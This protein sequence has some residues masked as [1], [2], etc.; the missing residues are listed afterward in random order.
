MKPSGGF[1]LAEYWSNDDE[2]P[3]VEITIALKDGTSIEPSTPKEDLADGT[4]GAAG[5]EYT[6]NIR[7]A[8]LSDD[9]H[10]G[11]VTAE[12]AQTPLNFRLA[13]LGTEQVIEDCNDA[14]NEQVV[15]DVTSGIDETDYKVVG[16]V[17]LTVAE[18]FATGILASEAIS[19]ALD[20]T[21]YKSVLLFVKSSIDM[22]AGDLQLLLDNSQNCGSPL[23]TLNL[24]AL[25][26]GLWTRVALTLAT[27]ANLTGIISV[28]IKL[29][30]NK[31][32]FILW[33]DD[34]RAPVT[35]WILKRA[36]PTH[37]DDPKVIGAF[38]AKKIAAKA[39]GTK[40]SDIL[41]FVP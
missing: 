38:F 31:G 28:G 8:E 7:T 4:D 1:S 40:E 2:S 32:A 9:V 16:A 29:T 13:G 25:S 10:D 21:A 3:L 35:S 39:A 30:A 20:L 24:P 19:P 18:N 11:L 12:E 17:K 33:I 26:A 5:K 27:P 14:W 6:F 36:I 23:E 41:L 22:A 34:V 15:S 37:V